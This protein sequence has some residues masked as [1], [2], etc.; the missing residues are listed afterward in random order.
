[1]NDRIKNFLILSISVFLIFSIIFTSRCLAYSIDDFINDILSLYST[2]TGSLQKES[3]YSRIS[4]Y[5]NI[6][7]SNK[8]NFLELAHKLSQLDSNRQLLIYKVLKKFIDPE[9][10]KLLF[11]AIFNVNLQ[12]INSEL[13]DKSGNF[14]EI[15]NTYDYQKDYLANTKENPKNEDQNITNDN[16]C[17]QSPEKSSEL[18]N[19]SN[20]KNNDSNPNENSEMKKEENNKQTS[21]NSNNK[22]IQNNS[23]KKENT[24]K[25]KKTDNQNQQADNSNNDSKELNIIDFK[26]DG[27]KVPQIPEIYKQYNEN[28]LE[29]LY[30]DALKLFYGGDLNKAFV[31]FWICL[32]NKYNSDGSC[33]YLG[34]IYEKNKDFDTAIILY[35]NSIN[36]FLSKTQVDAKFISYLY[37]RLGIT[38]NQKGMFEEAI[39]YLT[40]A[41]EY[42]PLDGE[43]YFQIGYSYYNLQNYEKAKLYFQKAYQLGFQKALEYIQKLGS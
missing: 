25:D 34:L 16:E 33:Y 1:M 7:L 26:L 11:P 20:N 13:K 40:K 3:I 39:L 19:Q 18:D 32:V 21:N 31:E 35:K 28:E 12:D 37:K 23:E 5:I 24:N 6:L 27:I 29:S 22:E 2:E 10:L 30:K 14:V 15:D 38:Y 9:N 36:L 17:N 43:S 41:I 8:E 42:Y 4:I